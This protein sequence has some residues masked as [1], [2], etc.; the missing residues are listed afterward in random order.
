M[1]SLASVAS[2]QAAVGLAAQ[3][4]QLECEQVRKAFWQ[5]GILHQNIL[6]SQE[7]VFAV[8][9]GQMK[10]IRPLQ[11]SASDLLR[12]WKLS[13][14]FAAGAARMLPQALNSLQK[15]QH[16]VHRFVGLMECLLKV[17]LS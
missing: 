13:K 12:Q 10:A 9:P 5:H 6:P 2:G 11:A 7:P 14:T 3:P 16:A 1:E 8:F 4:E 15:F 17:R